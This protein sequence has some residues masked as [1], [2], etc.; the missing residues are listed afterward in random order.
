MA[1]C[2][3]RTQIWQINQELNVAMR[4]PTPSMTPSSRTFETYQFNRHC[5]I[6]HSEPAWGFTQSS[7]LSGVDLTVTVTNW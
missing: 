5:H 4:H 7:R 3:P 1:S 2:N 6:C